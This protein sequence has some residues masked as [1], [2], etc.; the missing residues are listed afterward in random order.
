MS[1]DLFSQAVYKPLAAR[2]R[3]D[4]LDGFYGQQH[5]IGPTRPL[6]EAIDSGML[7]SM[8][9]WG[10]PGVGKTTLAKMIAHKVDA[11][12][13]SIWFFQNPRNF[14]EYYISFKTI[15]SFCKNN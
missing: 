8:I 9:F 1:D 2:M 6:R 15:D 4:S 7:H 3:P 5:L 10:P 11:H 14:F 12:F 13:E